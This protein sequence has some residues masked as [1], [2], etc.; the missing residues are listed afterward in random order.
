MT[1]VLQADGNLVIQR[2]LRVKTRLPPVTCGKTLP[3]LP[4]ACP[5]NFLPRLKS[6][7]TY[8]PASAVHRGSLLRLL[9]HHD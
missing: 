3:I 2:E 6:G 1:V 5:V 7:Q 8:L 9:N 4:T